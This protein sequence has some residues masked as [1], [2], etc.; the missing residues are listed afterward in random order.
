MSRSN[1]LHTV[2]LGLGLGTGIYYGSVGFQV[3]EE[4][5]E[6]H[7]LRKLA[8]TEEKAAQ[9]AESQQQ[10]EQAAV[11]RLEQQLQLQQQ[12]VTTLEQE[13]EATKRRVSEL[14]D[15]RSAR[16]KDAAETG[17]A[18]EAA[19]SKLSQLVEEMRK[20]RNNVTV[21]QEALGAAHSRM[22]E[23]RQLTNPLNHPMVKGLLK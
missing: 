12:E 4:A 14:E 16:V 9:E 2:L 11:R 7:R 8:Q 23:K 20:H 13:L 3:A 6:E 1:A 19:G 17:A 10:Y 5:R 22:L 18:I 15:L 21:A